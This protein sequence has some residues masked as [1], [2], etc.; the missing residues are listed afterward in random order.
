MA[1]TTDPRHRRL[2]AQLARAY[3]LEHRSKVQIA[4]DFGLSRFQVARLIDEAHD[5]GV[6]TITIES[7]QPDRGD[8]GDVIARELGVR[9]VEIVDGGSDTTVAMGRA[10][11]RHLDVSARP[12]QRIGLS[13]SRTIAAASAFVPALPRSTVVQLAGALQLDDAAPRQQV[14]TLLEQDP[15]VD[16]VR[17]PAPL[18]VTAPETAADLRALPEIRIALE[19]ADDLDLAIVSIGAWRGSLSSVRL[20]CGPDLRRAAE[21]AGAVAETSGRL[22]A[23]DG[24]P[25]TTLDDRVIAVTLDQLR[26]AGTTVGVAYGADRAAAVRAAARSGAFDVLIVDEPLAEELLSDAG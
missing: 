12:G 25:V 22:I 1:A 20:K 9:S 7:E 19:A 16:M 14:F 3:Y 2:L 13:W 10:A 5:S 4:D 18:L 17:L 21:E 6:V 11:L 23:A 15:D 8:R 26:A 24:S